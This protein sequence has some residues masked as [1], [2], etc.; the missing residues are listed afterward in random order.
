MDVWEMLGGGI[1]GDFGCLKDLLGGKGGFSGLMGVPISDSGTGKNG[2]L[3][4]AVWV[5]FLGI[6]VV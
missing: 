3:G 2:C 6:W 4:N 5:A 1:P